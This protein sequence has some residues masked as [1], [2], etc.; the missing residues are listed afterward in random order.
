MRLRPEARSRIVARWREV[1]A[2][3]L[4]HPRR[5]DRWQRGD[6]ILEQARALAAALEDPSRP[7]TPLYG[8]ADDA[9]AA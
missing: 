6:L 2:E 8:E 4:P 9:S 7:W 5:G 1:L 3:P